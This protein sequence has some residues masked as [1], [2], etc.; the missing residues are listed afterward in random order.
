MTHT[1]IWRAAKAKRFVTILGA[2]TSTPTSRETL[3]STLDSAHVRADT[4]ACY[5]ASGGWWKEVKAGVV[6]V[7]VGNFNPNYQNNSQR[8]YN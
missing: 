6:V 8:T 5:G 4:H 2:K 3:Q 7:V 1:L